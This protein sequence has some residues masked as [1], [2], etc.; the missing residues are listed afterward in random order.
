[1]R[2]PQEKFM[3]VLQERAEARGLEVLNAPQWANTGTLHFQSPS[4]FATLLSIPYD[5]QGGTLT[6]GWMS[7]A[8]S[9]SHPPVFRGRPNPW[10][11]GFDPEQH[12]DAIGALLDHCLK[13]VTEVES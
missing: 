3:A 12:G 6:L 2:T 8:H 10:F 4:E 7:G 5:F 11:A 13:P 1:M 9:G